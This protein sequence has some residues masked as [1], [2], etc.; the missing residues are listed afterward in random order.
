MEQ[1][2]RAAQRRA[3]IVATLAGMM[4]LCNVFA[5]NAQESF[6]PS[7]LTFHEGFGS[8]KADRRIY[9]VTGC[10]WIRGIRFGDPDQFVTNWIA[11]HPHA[12]ATPVSKMTLMSD[13][14]VYVSVKA[15]ERN[16][17]RGEQKHHRSDQSGL[18][19]TRNTS[20]FRSE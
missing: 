11:Q 10:G 15:L 19:Q 17:K 13:E 6:S 4:S 5:C 2:T 8:R 12:T 7:D 14:L 20:G 3:R 18:F 9:V 1:T 16:L